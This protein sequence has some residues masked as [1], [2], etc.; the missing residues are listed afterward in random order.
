MYAQAFGGP[1]WSED[2][3]AADGFIRRLS[4]DASRPEFISEGAFRDDR[5]LHEVVDAIEERWAQ[6]ERPQA[7]PAPQP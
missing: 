6:P 1:P 7:V 2:A 3:S 4:D 5:H